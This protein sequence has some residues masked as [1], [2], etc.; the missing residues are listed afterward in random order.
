MIGQS[1]ELPENIQSVLTAF[2]DSSKNTFKEDLRSIVLFGSGAEGNLRPASDVNVIVVLEKFDQTK[3][4]QM[5]E[6]LR[7]AETAIKLKAM[8]LLAHEVEPASQ[9]FSVKFADLKRRRKVLFGEDIFADLS[10]TRADSIFRLKQILL[11]LILRLRES[12]ISRGLREEQLALTIAETAGPLRACAATLLEM[13]GV[14]GLSPREALQSISSS[15]P[16]ADK[17]NQDLQ[18]LS[19]ARQKHALPPG[20]A[21]PTLFHLIELARLMWE[22]AALLK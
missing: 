14:S 19:E 20:A 2:V 17:F 21:G 13:E 22:R 12:Y 7:L 8:F 9:A 16:G 1:N 4:D 15:L 3:A 11:N 10:V 18:L 6:P 5:R